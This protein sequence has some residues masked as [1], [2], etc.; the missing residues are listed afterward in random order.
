MT[1]RTGH[2]TAP[3][4][5]APGRPEGA[6]AALGPQDSGRYQ[7]PHYQPGINLADRKSVV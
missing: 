5:T 7:R 1:P 3:P 4:L 6:P 2:D